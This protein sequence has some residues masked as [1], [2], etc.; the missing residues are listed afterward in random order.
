MTKRKIYEGTHL[1][2]RVVAYLGSILGHWLL[3]YKENTLY[4]NIN[5]GLN[6]KP[7]RAIFYKYFKKL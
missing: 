1:L 4:C 3:D 7:F 5:C 6:D 2:Y